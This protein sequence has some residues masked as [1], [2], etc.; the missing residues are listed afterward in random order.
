[1]K[2]VV[3]LLTALCCL[4]AAP[5]MA[6]TPG[7]TSFLEPT[8]IDTAGAAAADMA[9]FTQSLVAT[10]ATAFPVAIRNYEPPKLLSD[11]F[12]L[13]WDLDSLLSAAVEAGMDTPKTMA[14]GLEDLLRKAIVVGT[15]LRLESLMKLP[16]LQG[17]EPTVYPKLLEFLQLV[18]AKTR[19]AIRVGSHPPDTVSSM[20]GYV[21]TRAAELARHLPPYFYFEGSIEELLKFDSDTII[22]EALDLLTG[23]PTK[24][25]GEIVDLQ[26]L[27]AF[28]LET[29]GPKGWSLYT[30]PEVDFL[31]LSVLDDLTKLISGMFANR[32]PTGK[33]ELGMVLPALGLEVMIE[34]I[35]TFLN[36]FVMPMYNQALGVWTTIAGEFKGYADAFRDFISHTAAK[37]VETFLKMGKGWVDKLPRNELLSYFEKLATEL[38]AGVTARIP[39]CDRFPD[40]SFEKSLC[41]LFFSQTFGPKARRRLMYDPS[42]PPSKNQAAGEV[43]ITNLGIEREPTLLSTAIQPISIGYD[44]LKPLADIFMGD[45]NGKIVEYTDLELHTFLQEA[46]APFVHMM[47][48]LAATFHKILAAG[49]YSCEKADCEAEKH[50]FE[51]MMSVNVIEGFK[52]LQPAAGYA[53]K[54]TTDVYEFMTRLAKEL[55][56]EART[57]AEMFPKLPFLPP[58][59]VKVPHF[60]P[61]DALTHL[62]DL[63]SHLMGE[64]TKPEL[65]KPIGGGAATK[66]LAGFFKSP[67][68]KTME[69]LDMFVKELVKAFEPF[70]KILSG[71]FWDVAS[72]NFV[73][74]EGGKMLREFRRYFDLSGPVNEKSRAN[75]L[76]DVAAAII[77]DAQ[78]RIP[79]IERLA[80]SF[81]K[82]LFKLFQDALKG[83]YEIT[84]SLLTG[85]PKPVMDLLSPDEWGG[86]L[87]HVLAPF[88]ELLRLG[89]DGHHK[90]AGHDQ[91]TLFDQYLPKLA[92]DGYH[93]LLGQLSSSHLSMLLPTAITTPPVV[94]EIQG[95]V[96]RLAH[97]WLAIAEHFVGA[98]FKLPYLPPV[99]PHVPDLLHVDKYFKGLLD[100]I[101]PPPAGFPKGLPIYNP[102]EELLVV[103]SKIA[104]SLAGL[105]GSL[106]TP[107]I[108]FLDVLTY[109]G[110]IVTPDIPFLKEFTEILGKLPDRGKELTAKWL[111]GFK[112]FAGHPM[113]ILKLA[114]SFLEKVA[115]T[116]WGMMPLFDPDHFHGFIDMVAPFTYGNLNKLITYLTQLPLSE[117][118]NF[119]KDITAFI[120][121]IITHTI[122]EPANYIMSMGEELLGAYLYRFDALINPQYTDAEKAVKGTM[123]KAGSIQAGDIDKV[124]Q[125]ILTPT[126]ITSLGTEAMT[127]V[128]TEVTTFFDGLVRGRAANSRR[129]RLQLGFAP[130]ST[131]LLSTNLV[132]DYLVRRAASSLES[133]V[134]QP[135]AGIGM[136]VG[137]GGMGM[138][139][140]VDPLGGIAATTSGIVDGGAAAAQGILS[141]AE[142][143]LTPQQ[144]QQ[145]SLLPGLTGGTSSLLQPA[146]TDLLNEL[147]P[148]QTGPSLLDPVLGGGIPGVTPPLF[149][150]LTAMDV[151]TIVQFHL[152]PSSGG[153]I[154]GGM[155]GERVPTRV[156]DLGWEGQKRQVGERI[157]RFAEKVT[158]KKKG[159]DRQYMSEPSKVRAFNDHLYMRTIEAANLVS[160]YLTSNPGIGPM[161]LEQYLNDKA[162]EV[163]NEAL[164]FIAGWSTPLFSSSRLFYDAV[165]WPQAPSMPGALNDVADAAWLSQWFGAL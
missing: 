165:D 156:A 59:P 132:D 10:T 65:T 128:R 136:G 117:L 98:Y 144:Q 111:A 44:L 83:G 42:K 113:E 79:A 76:R 27:I 146:E 41:D 135:L 153:T 130:T 161:A 94:K 129:R 121:N 86:F 149:P 115:K 33:E 131:S 57:Y 158:T 107:T 45:R 139:M 15:P 77:K 89:G 140:G 56:Y 134:T 91:K 1:M 7:A 36:D 52:L 22:R 155:M 106:P 12:P 25:P 119:M 92:V 24:F 88:L 116:V 4:L 50:V 99:L 38:L 43:Y 96:E 30:S 145:P 49:G 68:S 46:L 53:E 142:A 104:G 127:S 51:N 82:G 108:P 159:F 133:M 63:A 11:E 6:Q 13:R 5:V 72:I 103:P 58:P 118:P 148:L 74:H 31:P 126:A 18:V 47:Q 90:E 102:F 69:I 35:E 120:E 163:Y 26:S 40:K 2:P 114:V 60:Q 122:E 138:G 137:M 71:G 100:L 54:V 23:I 14:E 67:L 125:A 124:I 109:G 162:D 141:E 70:S 3:V 9:A 101:P 21:T 105:A 16:D 87:E 48:Q 39:T 20:L 73:S 95:L 151:A 157:D 28:D 55:F 64:L 80:D 164:E 84:P 147:M 112:K 154:S 110:S 37:Y 8:L 66:A 150:G 78:L 32:Q 81:D 34:P 152:Q 62:D 75:Y 97:E 61:L 85:L 143:L 93:V 29:L 123:D 160:S 17:Y 19:A